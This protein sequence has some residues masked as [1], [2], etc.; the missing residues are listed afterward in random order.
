MTNIIKRAFDKISPSPESLGRELTQEINS[1]NNKTTDPAKV[2]SLIERGAIIDAPSGRHG[3]HVDTYNTPL[4]VWAARESQLAILNAALQRGADPNK[5]NYFSPGQIPPIVA[6][7]QQGHADIIK[8][9]LKAGAKVDKGDEGQLTALNWACANEHWD[10]AEL[11]LQNG[12]NPNSYKSRNMYTTPLM[13]VAE[14]GNAKI[15]KLLIEKGADITKTDSYGRTA[16]IRAAQEGQLETVKVLVDNNADIFIKEKYLE[17]TALGMARH[18][19]HTE[20]A[21]FLEVTEARLQKKIYNEKKARNK[22]PI[23]RPE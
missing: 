13:V 9:L 23:F 19:G 17:V 1:L 15:L 21:A 18:Q 6:A 22:A 16:L 8:S 11:L 12:A 4:L 3:F 2:L 20:V 10:V 14:K 7:A 5:T